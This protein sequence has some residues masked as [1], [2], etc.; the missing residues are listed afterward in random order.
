MLMKSAWFGE[1][2]IVERGKH[3]ELLALDGYYKKA[4]RYAKSVNGFFFF[5][6]QQVFLPFFGFPFRIGGILVFF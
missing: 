6:N 3:E 1:G 2:E 5:R 4:K